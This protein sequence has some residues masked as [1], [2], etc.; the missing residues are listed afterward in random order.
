M[1]V[2]SKF[3]T[4][5]HHKKV[6]KTNKKSGN[7]TQGLFEDWGVGDIFGQFLL[8]LNLKAQWL[9]PCECAYTLLF[10]NMS[11]S[12]ILWEEKLTRIQRPG[13]HFPFSQET[14]VRV[15]QVSWPLDLSLKEGFSSIHLLAVWTWANYLI[16]PFLYSLAKCGYD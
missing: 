6:S 4:T 2:L 13:A 10:L 7:L 14:S 1:S 16:S 3:Y 5:N 15:G 9:Q 12:M 8:T 11:R